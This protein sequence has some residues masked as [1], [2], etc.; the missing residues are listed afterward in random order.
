MSDAVHVSE[1]RWLE[2]WDRQN[3]A[4]LAGVIPDA[5]RQRWRWDRD[6]DEDG[7]E[8]LVAP[9][10]WNTGR[11]VLGQAGVQAHSLRTRSW[12]WSSLAFMT[13]ELTRLCGHRMA[14]R[15]RMR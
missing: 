11:V 15:P 3:S 8:I 6:V 2:H 14:T 5:I 4:T 13:L 7:D 12:T 1:H 9:A 10:R